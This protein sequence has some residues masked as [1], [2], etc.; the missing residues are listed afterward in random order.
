[1][2]L[3]FAILHNGHK[4][5]ACCCHLSDFS[6]D[7]GNNTVGITAQF[8]I[9]CFVKVYGSLSLRL[10]QGSVGCIKL[11]LV[12]VVNCLAYG[13]TFVQLGKAFCVIRCQLLVGNGTGKLCLASCQGLVNIL[14]VNGHEDLSCSNLITYIDIA[15]VY[16]TG[17]LEGKVAF[18]ATTHF[19]GINICSNGAHFTNGNGTHQGNNL[20]GLRLGSDNTVKLPA[21][22]KNQS[23]SGK[24][25]HLFLRHVFKKSL[26]GHNTPPN[27]L[28]YLL[29]EARYVFKTWVR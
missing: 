7:I 12:L 24:G 26:E 19:T 9:F 16:L 25:N 15:I 5:I 10:S 20:G 3:T 17:N 11:S 8:G 13:A 28:Y 6:D 29:K 14:G 27:S 4:G 22:S 21:C 2:Y 23:R 1:M 18:V